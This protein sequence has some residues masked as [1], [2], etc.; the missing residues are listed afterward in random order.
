MLLN[1]ATEAFKSVHEVELDTLRS[2]IVKRVP[3][4]WIFRA[5]CVWICVKPV[6]ERVNVCLATEPAFDEEGMAF[7]TFLT[8]VR[9]RRRTST[10]ELSWN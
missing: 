8:W 3:D 10:K 9:S 4:L 5:Q 2:S 6:F 1:K 7:A